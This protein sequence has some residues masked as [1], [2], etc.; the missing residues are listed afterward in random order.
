[1][2]KVPGG[3]RR[4]DQVGEANHTMMS[5]NDGDTV[6]VNSGA[7]PATTHFVVTPPADHS[8]T[9]GERKSQCSSL[10]DAENYEWNGEEEADELEKQK[11]NG[12]NSINELKSPSGIN[13]NTWLRTSLRRTPSN[14]P[15]ALSNRRWG[16]FRHNGRKNQA[17]SSTALA[18]QLYRS[19]SFNSSGRSS[20]CDT[21]DDMYSDAS[22]E[23]DVH[24]LHNKRRKMG[25][26]KSHVTA[27]SDS[28]SVENDDE[29][30]FD[31]WEGQ[32]EFLGNSQPD[33]DAVT[34]QDD[35]GS[36][37]YANGLKKHLLYDNDST[38]Q[39]LQQKVDV[40][41]DSAQQNDERYTR[42]KADNAALQARILMLEDQLRDTEYR[43]EE[44][45][46]D[47]QRRC[48]ELVQRIEREKQLQLENAAI[49][50]QSAQ[51]ECDKLKEEVVRQR[52]KLEKLEKQKDD[53]TTQMGDVNYELNEAKEEVKECKNRENRLLKDRDAQ[54]QLLEDLSKEIERLKLEHRTPALPTTSPEALRLD[55][56]HEEM[57]MLRAEN[58]QLQEANEELQASLLHAG[59]E[60]GRMLTN[61]ENS[62]AHELDIMSQDEALKEQQEV[63]RQ[64][65][66][67]IEGILLNIVE[68]HPQLL[69]VKQKKNG[70]KN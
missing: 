37:V 42:L 5:P 9:N 35:D 36:L 3:D 70:L 32:F 43:C 58:S 46:Q 10:S 2:C 4:R 12:N 6:I 11:R 59:L 50:L 38:F 31:M 64:L 7:A 54:M 40:L 51:S 20:T 60:T 62:L 33:T 68:N 23:E 56:L 48:K 47:E 63:N 13:R 28:E 25:D 8:A 22:L 1:M 19:S 30:F 69:E 57:S 41:Q 18:S 34:Y 27:L 17:L 53:L 14:N 67:Y 29:Y 21:T 65:R 52:T 44:K 61:G 24:E 39:V 26:T 66:T 55:E 49:R 45:I 15:E 16:S